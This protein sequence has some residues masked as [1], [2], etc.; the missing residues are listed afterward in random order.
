MR[1]Y[2]HKRVIEGKR[3]TRRSWGAGT[4]IKHLVISIGYKINIVNADP[5]PQDR[6]QETKKRRTRYGGG[7]PRGGAR[8]MYL[9]CRVSSEVIGIIAWSSTEIKTLR[10]IN[11]AR[12]GF[13]D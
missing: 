13:R 2:V 12:S 5:D 7:L 4:E 10:V 6:N 1:K 9:H 8:K 11:D 3:K